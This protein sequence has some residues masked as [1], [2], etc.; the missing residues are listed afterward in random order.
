M[1]GI[2]RFIILSAILGCGGQF[3]S[4][5][6]NV[7]ID[8]RGIHFSLLFSTEDGDHPTVVADF[9][10]DFANLHFSSRAL[11]CRQSLACLTFVALR[12]IRISVENLS[13]VHP[14]ESI[15]GGRS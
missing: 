3:S 10:G 6:G 7:S 11:Q 8:L 5:P 14:V 1:W 12:N 4:L 9:C 13:R 2:S 15:E